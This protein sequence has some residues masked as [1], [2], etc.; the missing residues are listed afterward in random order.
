[1]RAP[2]DVPCVV[3]VATP[4]TTAIRRPGVG[5]REEMRVRRSRA[6]AW[7][8]AAPRSA[9]PSRYSRSPGVVARRDDRAPCSR[10]Q[11]LVRGAC[12]RAVRCAGSTASSAAGVIAP[13]RRR[14][15]RAA[16]RAPS[17]AGRTSACRRHRPRARRESATW[18]AGPSLR[19]RMFQTRPG[20]GR[21]HEEPR[22][23][24][25]PRL[26]HGPRRTRSTARA[27]RSPAARP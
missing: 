9:R 22:L 27:R 4:S 23:A 13:G 11:E 8:Q 5:Q 17:S 7:A 15:R 24:E 19:S 2:G 6:P 20:R 1:M 18:V 21:R 14:R 25:A 10:D 26:R 3:P 16:S 12:A